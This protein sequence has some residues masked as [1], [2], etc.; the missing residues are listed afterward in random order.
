MGKNGDFEVLHPEWDD[1]ELSFKKDTVARGTD[2]PLTVYIS[3]PDIRKAP[4]RN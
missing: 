3:P 4:R 2:D 1:E